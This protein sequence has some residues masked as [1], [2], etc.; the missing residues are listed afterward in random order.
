MFSNRKKRRDENRNRVDIQVAVMLSSIVVLTSILIF[1]I[2]Y[3]VSYSDMIRSLQDRV[4]AIYHGIEEQLNTEDFKNINK[5]EDVSKESYKEM[6]SIL[7]RAKETAGVLY[8]YT[9]KALD[10][11]DFIYVVDG[12]SSEGA[13]FRFPGDLIE[14]EIQ[15]EMRDALTSE[16]V[17]PRKIKDT[18]WGPIFIAYLPIIDGDE[19]VGVLGVEFDAGHQYSTYLMLMISMPLLI[20]FA[21]SIGSYVAF[22]LFRRISNPTFQDL[23]NT[24][25]LTGLKNRNAF[26]IDINNL[27]NRNRKD[28]AMISIDLDDLKKIN[29][30][31]GHF[32][33][34]YYIKNCVELLQQETSRTRVLYR[35]GGDEF[36]FIM[37]SLEE[38]PQEV[39]T[40]IEKKMS[41]RNESLVNKISLSA[42]CAIYEEGSDN[43]LGDTFHRADKNM[44]LL[45]R[46]KKTKENNITDRRV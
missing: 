34:D 3:V 2:T 15:A 24:D 7:F 37:F 32:E 38:M 12:L 10:N 13:D 9:A 41:I 17:M 35:V 43:D 39:I 30:T 44:Y 6:Q 46:R 8:L 31:K 4:S 25:M 5:K 23:A 29:D 40:R 42:G 20:L 33:G 19:V 22:K 1:V 28:I 11:G 16:V 18:S 21:C 36:A 45:K 27:N 14:E 26:D